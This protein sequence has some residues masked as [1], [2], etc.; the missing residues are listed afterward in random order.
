MN[1]EFRFADAAFTP[2]EFLRLA[3]RV[4]P[5]NYD[6]SLAAAALQRTVNVGAWHDGAS[7]DPS[8]C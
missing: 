1:V 3:N 6:L 4:W 8:A 7:W 2:G 5:R